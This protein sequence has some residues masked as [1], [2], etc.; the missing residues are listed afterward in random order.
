MPLVLSTTKGLEEETLLTMS[1]VLAEVLGAPQSARV[2]VLSG[3][4]FAAEVARGLPTAVTVAATRQAV[5]KRVQ[6]IFSSPRFRVYTTEDLIGVEI[7]GAVKNV[8]AIAAGVSDGLKYGHSARAALITR[9][10]AEVTRL[11]VRLGAQP[12]T[13]SGLSGMGDL[14]LTCTSDLS[15][16]HRVGVRLGQG[17]QLEAVLQGMPMVAEGIRTCRSVFT[18]AQRLGVEMPIVEQMYALLYDKKSPHQVVAD[19][20]ARGVKPEFS[21]QEN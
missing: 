14:V 8:I 4:S 15:R 5:A 20:L 9:G 10:L 2:A 6:A 19:L 11:A 18:L 21:S 7:G 16:N 1:A 12:Q 3:P 17:E 13:L